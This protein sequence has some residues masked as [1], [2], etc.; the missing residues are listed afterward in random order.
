MIWG[1]GGKGAEEG[2]A[3]GEVGQEVGE[4]LVDL[5]RKRVEGGNEGLEQL[6]ALL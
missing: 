1:I 4:G 3:D 5:G 6:V 2:S